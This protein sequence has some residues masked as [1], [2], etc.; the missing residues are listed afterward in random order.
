MNLCTPFI[1][2]RHGEFLPT[3]LLPGPME[4]VTTGEFLKVMTRHQWIQAWWTPF[5][6]ISQAV[7][8]PGRLKHWLAPYQDGNLP[9]LVQLMGTHSERLARAAKEMLL[10]G[11]RGIDLN[12]ACPSPVVLGNGAGGAR[13]K[14]PE[15]L[16]EAI[17]AIKSAVECPI[18]IKVRM[19][20]TSPSEFRERIAPAIREGAPDFVTVHFR[21]VR[22]SYNAIPNGLERLKEARKALPDI[23]LVGSG[24]LFT[25]QDVIR[26]R[27]QC[28][29]DAV[30]P[31]R[32]LLR[33]P[34]LLVD[35]RQTLQN[36]PPPPWT[37]NEKYALL[38][39]FQECGAT[40]GFVLRMAAN[41]FGRTSQEFLEIVRKLVP[42]KKI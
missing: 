40:L 36:A 5:L 7:P 21:T 24:D 3:R 1:L 29:V 42:Q 25:P 18:G 27:D 9:V 32:G 14:T 12:C 23:P 28:G 39:E 41:L 11:A 16:A 6:R 31:A 4:G 34:R 19:G 17:C 13:L 10:Q 22:E 26:M 20:F 2:P 37:P 33:N 35:I 30:A 15:W 8:R 38:R